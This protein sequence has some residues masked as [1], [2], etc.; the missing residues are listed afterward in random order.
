MKAH[1]RVVRPFIGIK[2]LQLNESK[3]GQLRRADPAFPAVK[4][5]IL[6]PQVS[7]GSPAA[8]AGLCPGDIIIGELFLY[9]TA[10]QALTSPSCLR[11]ISKC[12]RWAHMLSVLMHGLCCKQRGLESASGTSLL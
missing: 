10:R 8:R 5:G 2:M 7:H 4:A 9:L 12:I 11:V 3:V 1:G 6:V